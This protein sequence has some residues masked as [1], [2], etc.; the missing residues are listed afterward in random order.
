M[1]LSL[2]GPSV[3]G[4]RGLWDVI[5]SKWLLAAYRGL[6]EGALSSAGLCGPPW[7]S[8][9]TGLAPVRGKWARRK[10]VV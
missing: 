10:E 2:L 8:A 1:A 4:G 5:G 7:P 9:Q 3:A 6:T